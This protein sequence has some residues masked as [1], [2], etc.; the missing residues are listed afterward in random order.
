MI[1]KAYTPIVAVVENNKNR[2]LFDIISKIYASTKLH[3]NTY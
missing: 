3:I 2:M 1:T